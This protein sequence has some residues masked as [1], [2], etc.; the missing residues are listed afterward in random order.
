MSETEEPGRMASVNPEQFQQQLSHTTTNTGF[1]FAGTPL[2]F[3][4]QEPRICVKLSYQ[5]T[6]CDFILFGGGETLKKQWRLL[7]DEEKVGR[8]RRRKAMSIRSSIRSSGTYSTAQAVIYLFQ[9]ARE[10]KKKSM[11]RQYI[12]LDEDTSGPALLDNT[13]GRQC[14]HPAP[15]CCCCIPCVPVPALDLLSQR[16]RSRR[17]ALLIALLLALSLSTVTWK[18]LF[19]EEPPAFESVDRGQSNNET[20]ISQF[21]WIEKYKADAVVSFFHLLLVLPA[22]SEYQ[23]VYMTIP[24][25]V[26]TSSSI[27]YQCWR[28]TKG[29]ADSSFILTRALWWT[30][31]ACLILVWIHLSEILIRHHTTRPISFTSERF[32]VFSSYVR[33]RLRRPA[34]RPGTWEDRKRIKK[35]MKR[36]AVHE[37]ATVWE[38]VKTAAYNALPWVMITY[39][40][41]QR[42]FFKVSTSDEEK[43]AFYWPLRLWI[44]LFCSECFIVVASG[45]FFYVIGVVWQIIYIPIKDHMWPDTLELIGKIVQIVLPCIV[46]AVMFLMHVNWLMYFLRYRQLIL[47]MR[48]GRYDIAKDRMSCTSVT[49]YIG[50]QIAYSTLTVALCFGLATI[51]AGVIVA[52][53]F[54]EEFRS[55]SLRYLGTILVT[56]IINFILRTLVNLIYTTDGGRMIRNYRLFSYADM[57]ITLS[58][59]FTGLVAGIVRLVTALACAVVNFSRFDTPLIGGSLDFLDGGYNSFISVLWT[60]YHSSNNPIILVAADIFVR[61]AIMNQTDCRIDMEVDGLAVKMTRV[62]RRRIINRWWLY[63]VLSN[64]PVLLPTRKSQLEEEEVIELP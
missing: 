57:L 25:I 39:S 53:V 13:Y 43:R 15:G 21:S 38:R 58:S 26:W 11:R 56:A 9:R 5:A 19:N 29:A 55:Y 28:H 63:V 2:S 36:R 17:L 49:Q 59:T 41:T 62:K 7:H 64:N 31:L 8:E 30:N 48:Q 60:D 42:G 40:S 10:K 20:N 22:N 52:M 50:L 33:N 3:G 35:V 16:V 37:G 6:F 61:A 14:C 12:R 27:G 54:Q 47:D 51:I 4:P 18:S 34:V 46:G 32:Q 1:K 44:G 23:T 24:G 45:I